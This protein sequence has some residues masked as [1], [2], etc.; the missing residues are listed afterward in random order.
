MTFFDDAVRLKLAGAEVPIVSQYEVNCGVMDVP[1]QFS[2]TIGHGGLWRDLASAFPPE[3]PFE[4]LIGDRTIFVGETDE[5]ATEGAPTTMPIVGRDYLRRLADSFVASE[6]TF[7]EKTFAD[8]TRIALED[9]GLGDR[10]ITAFNTAN[11]LAVTGIQTIE[12]LSVPATE[13]T[14]IETVATNSTKTVRRTLKAELGSKWWDFLCTQYRRSGLFLWSDFEGNFVLSR[15]NGNQAPVA[16]IVRRLGGDFGDVSVVG[17][18][19]FKHNTSN[20][21]TECLVYH[22][23]GGGKHGRSK[24]SGRFVDEEMVAILNPDPA[25]RADGGKRKKLL[26]VKDQQSKTIQQANYLARRKIVESRRNGWQLSYTVSGHSAPALRGGGRVIWQPDTVVH[27]IDEELGI[28]GPMYVESV[29]FSRTPQTNTRIRLMRCEDLL[30]AEEPDEQ[31]KHRLAA[32]PGAVPAQDPDLRVKV[33]EG[34]N[35]W[36]VDPNRT[37]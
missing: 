28:D 17:V 33:S 26:V 25:D 9:V 20:R 32:K 6:R 4:L 12:E 2:N 37:R 13:D 11:R 1:A 18:P 19:S 34:T 16:R 7:S 35:L 3:T 23:T 10:S 15:P 27:V 31:P 8:L 21:Y 5:I 24:A 14:T 36:Q 30:F 22:R 29:K